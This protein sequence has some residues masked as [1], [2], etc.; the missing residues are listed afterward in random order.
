MLLKKNEQ[1]THE[2]NFE[3]TYHIYQFNE[4]E[5][6]SARKFCDNEG[7]RFAPNYAILMDKN[8]C[9]HYATNKMDYEELKDISKDLFLGVLDEQIRVSPRNYCDFQERFLFVNI[10]GD[11]RICSS[12]PK[13]FEQNILIGNIVSGNIDDVFYKKFHFPR[14]DECIGMG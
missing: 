13:N 4:G 10:D 1:S 2:I 7:I 9:R 14:C 11:I 5:M 3:M 12:F 8:K 6:T